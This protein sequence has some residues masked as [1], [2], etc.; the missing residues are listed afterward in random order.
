MIISCS[1]CKGEFEVSAA[2]IPPQGL[3]TTCP[4]CRT[5]FKAMPEDA[6]GAPAD[7]GGEESVFVRRASGKVFGPLAMPSVVSMVQNQTLQPEDE[8]S[9]DGETWVPLTHDP[10]LGPLV[11]GS[12]EPA[13]EEGF[14][15]NVITPVPLEGGAGQADVDMEEGSSLHLDTD[16]ETAGGVP[17]DDLNDGVAPAEP[18][19]GPPPGGM[20]DNMSGAGG[21]E[22]APVPSISLDDFNQPGAAPGEAGPGDFQL[23]EPDLPQPKDGLADLPQPKDDGLADLPMPKADPL[24]DLPA[25]K[26]GLQGTVMGMG[27]PMAGGQGEAE[28]PIP[29]EGIVDLPEPKGGISDVM[30]PKGGISDVVEP[31]GG[32]ADYPEPQGGITDFPEPQGGIADFPEPQGGISDF[33]EPQGGIA[34]FPEPQGG[35]SDFPEPQGGISDFPEPEGGISDFPEPQGLEG[36]FEYSDEAGMEEGGGAFGDLDD[37]PVS[38]DGDG[39]DGAFAPTEGTGDALRFDA[40]SAADVAEISDI[41]DA[42]KK[43]PK[44]PR[45]KRELTRM[46]MIRMAV[47]GVVGILLLGIGMGL[48]TDFGFFGLHYLTGGFEKERKAKDTMAHLQKEMGKDT[49]A[50][51]RKALRGLESVS[52]VLTEN[53]DPMALQVQAVSAMLLRFGANKA[54]KAKATEMLTGLRQADANSREVDKATALVMAFL[55]KQ[56]KALATINKVIAKD[57]RDAVAR[58][59]EGWIY[60]QGR[61]YKEAGKAYD[62]AVKVDSKL[63]AALYGVARV[64]ELQGNY[65]GAATATEIC[66]KANP[67]HTGAILLKARLMARDKKA[68]QVKL[69]LEKVIKQKKLAAPIEKAEAYVTLGSLNLDTGSLNAARDNFK[70]ALKLNPDAS[71][72]LLGL[73]NLLYQAKKYGEAL[74]QFQSARKLEPNNIDASFM[75]ARTMLALG[76]PMDALKAL[77]AIGPGAKERAELPFLLGRVE[78]ELG[79][80]KDAEKHFR[81]AMKKQP[82][83]FKPYL[84]LSRI[85]MKQNEQKKALGVL[86]EAQSKM[87]KSG[88]VLNAQGEVY[89][90]GKHWKKALAKFQRALA[91]DSNLNLAI[92]NM[93][94]CLFELG[95]YKK[96]RDKYMELQKRDDQFPGLAAK[97]ADLFTRLGAHADAAKQWEIALKQET[98]TVDRQIKAARSFVSAGIYKRAL[99]ETEKALRKDASLAEARAIRA[100]ALLALSTS[101][102]DSRLGDALVEINNALGRVQRAPYYVTLG[103]IHLKRDKELEAIDAFSSA[104]K[105]DPSLVDIQTKRAILLIKNGTVKD[106]LLQ[107]KKTAG[108]YPKRGDIHLYMGKALYDLGEE[109]KALGAFRTATARDPALGE[110]HYRI[111]LILYDRR[112]FT[113]AIPLLNRAVAAK[114]KGTGSW[115][116]DAHLHLGFV[117]EKLKNRKKT[118]EAYKKYMEVAKPTAA[119]RHEVE[120]RLRAMGVI[121]DEE[122]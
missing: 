117:Y 15:G 105:L 58:V 48:F 32:I 96:A 83:Y 9:A 24:A 111:A 95:S 26:M 73:G 122:F 39:E 77:M 108:H 14:S 120:K 42:K 97:M 55:A 106:G 65:K 75:I 63:P 118:I 46:D 50:S 104:L 20:G 94:N 98:P 34:D 19:P 113:S 51:Y 92:F 12:P 70:K 121:K 11:V 7:T 119:M 44:A 99:D 2:S 88:L 60:Q 68:Q 69:L 90:A 100:E 10:T 59:Y 38:A 13:A 4:H 8:V 112:A 40:P 53:P 93:A 6:G 66:L 82:K 37:M 84:H 33:P 86:S 89:L 5:T 102:D 45:K 43:E 21:E 16:G 35:I 110:A 54:R 17:L 101:R 23:E 64:Q 25:P 103:E 27:D 91:K 85:Y 116:E 22:W 115:I 57:K 78:E 79:E 74:K 31:Q 107:L 1:N 29:K 61:Q 109:A 87:P 80:F 28:L 62:A 52:K 49:Y 56:D 3:V 30:E 81:E 71:A 36:F 47:L 67:N 114:K 18:P 41:E 76:K 72:A